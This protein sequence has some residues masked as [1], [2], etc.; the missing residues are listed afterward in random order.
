MAEPG[1]IG[2]PRTGCGF[3]RPGLIEAKGTASERGAARLAH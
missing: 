1:F 2:L 3:L